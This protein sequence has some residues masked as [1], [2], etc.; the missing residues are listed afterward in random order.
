MFF[1][2]KLTDKNKVVFNLKS[3]LRRLSFIFRLRE[4]S[5][6]LMCSARFLLLLFVH[7]KIKFTKMKL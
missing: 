7:N 1:L 4:N 6:K 5:L 2:T 3:F